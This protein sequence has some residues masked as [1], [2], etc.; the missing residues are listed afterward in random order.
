M[1]RKYASVQGVRNRTRK[2]NIESNA[3]R[4]PAKGLALPLTYRISARPI[5]SRRLKI[6][7]LPALVK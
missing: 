7:P 2:T 5:G 4:L 1:M 3:Q 6:T